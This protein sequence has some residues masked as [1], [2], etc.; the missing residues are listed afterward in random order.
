M[1]NGEMGVLSL[2]GAGYVHG[3]PAAYFSLRRGTAVVV[4]DLHAEGGLLAA[5]CLR[6]LIAAVDPD[7]VVVAGDAFDALERYEFAEPMARYL[8][9]LLGASPSLRE[10]LVALSAGPH[11]P[12]IGGPCRRF[13]AGG[14]VVTAVGGVAVIRAGGL[15]V[16]VLH[17]DQ[18]LRSGVLAALINLAMG[19]GFYESLA[20]R[21]L[22]IGPGP[23]VVM[24]HT[25]LP[26][27]DASRGLANTGSWSW[28]PLIGRPAAALVVS[29]PGAG[30]ASARMLRVR[31]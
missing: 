2:E 17:G 13:Q 15:H 4:S 28:R 25:H 23:L 24:G 29:A 6:R 31:C 5:G 19:R 8:A 16:A 12:K 14:V 3:V 26:F 20:R 11:D 21:R 27:F 10:I 1:Q 30:G 7:L 18:L 9:G 22:G